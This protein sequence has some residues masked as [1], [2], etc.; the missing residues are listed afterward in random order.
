M[1]RPFIL[2]LIL[3]ITSTNCFAAVTSS[4][5]PNADAAPNEWDLTGGDGTN[6]YTPV[7]ETPASDADYLATTTTLYDEEFDYPTET[8]TG[9]IA[10]TSVTVYVRVYGVHTAPGGSPADPE[11]GINIYMGSAWQ[12]QQ[13]RTVT[14]SIWIDETFTF[15]GTWTQADL[16]A[17]QTRCRRTSG[18]APNGGG[19]LQFSQIYI[20]ATYTTSGIKTINGLAKA[21]VKTWNGLAI[22]SVKTINGLQ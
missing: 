15:D 13:T 11:I 7:D 2:L 5:F 14:G 9:L 12:T 10:I 4:L 1:R 8:L 18:N 17:I 19:V 16:D 6:H 3:F 21:S 22:A 20:I